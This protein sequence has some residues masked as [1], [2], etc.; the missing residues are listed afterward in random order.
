[1]IGDP[2]LV[3]YDSKKGYWFLSQGR[4]TFYDDDRYLR[5]W[6]SKDAAVEWAMDELGVVPLDF[7]ADPVGIMMEQRA[8]DNKQMRMEL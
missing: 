5:T 7:E 1:M 4:E 2:V 8:R 6:E 3:R